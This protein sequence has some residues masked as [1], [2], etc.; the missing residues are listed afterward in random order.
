[1]DVLIKE[2]IFREYFKNFNKHFL[3]QLFAIYQVDT[4]EDLFWFIFIIVLASILIPVIIGI[5]VSIVIF[6]FVKKASDA[7]KRNR[8]MDENSNFKKLIL[9]L[10]F[11]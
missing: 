2:L 1:M 8:S 3:N 9:H 10:N 7:H 4:M 5:I 11:I 6:V